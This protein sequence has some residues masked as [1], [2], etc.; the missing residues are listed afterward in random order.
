MDSPRLKCIWF[1]HLN[2]ELPYNN[3]YERR[4]IMKS[5]KMKKRYFWAV[6][7]L[8]ASIGL[9]GCSSADSSTEGNAEYDEAFEYE[10]AGE[11]A[12][13][14]DVSDESLNTV[15]EKGIDVA[16]TSRKL[17][18]TVNI[19]AQTRK[20]DTFLSTLNQ[21]VNDIQGYVQS[22]EISGNNYDNSS[23]RSASYTIRIPAEKLSEF[24]TAVKE[25]ANIVYES[26]S[27]EDITLEYV[28]TESRVA[29]LKTEQ[30]SLMTMLEAADSLEDI[31]KIQSRLTEVRYEI[32]SYESQLRTYD[33]LVSYSTVYLDINEVE[34]ET[35][36]EDSSFWKIAA[37]RLGN[38]VYD[39]K[40][41]SRNLLIWLIAMLPYIIILAVL[42]GIVLFIIRKADN[43]NRKNPIKNQSETTGTD[44]EEDG[45]D[46]RSD[47]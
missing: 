2:A 4:M 32:E 24:L 12:G 8:L 30:E 11:D 27:A 15:S 28:D 26:E 44:R 9:S 42:L 33:N 41:G 13:A 34:R 19:T 45:G 6:C 43:K 21:Q 29:A 3:V 17:I 22:S 14:D 5:K 47:R 36:T 39:I 25:N 38:S 37:D 31:I 40:E 1:L 23:S 16:D 35:P 20:F 7:L 10:A 18:K 46:G